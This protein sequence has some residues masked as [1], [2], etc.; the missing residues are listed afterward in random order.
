MRN[1][2]ANFLA[3]LR[4]SASLPVVNLLEFTVK[5]DDFYL[6]TNDTSLTWDGKFWK[7]SSFKWDSTQFS[8]E[9]VVSFMIFSLDDINKQFYQ[10]FI[11]SLPDPYPVS[12]YLA[13]LDE[14]YQIQSTILLFKGYIDNWGYDQTVLQMECSSLLNQ[15]NRRTIRMFS[16]SCRW[17]A[18]RGPECKYMGEQ[19]QCDRTYVQCESYGNTVN[20]GGYRWL[21]LLQNK[22]IL[23]G[24][25]TDN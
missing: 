21:P 20:F 10:V 4:A 13:S 24:K 25:K 11:D 17:A 5:D 8:N 23:W 14:A 2:D 15:W 18:F 12:F 19:Q 3:E 16:G 22:K 6:T 9:E 7:S 1:I